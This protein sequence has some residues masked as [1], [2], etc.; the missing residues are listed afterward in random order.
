MRKLNKPCRRA[1]GNRCVEAYHSEGGTHD[2]SH[3]IA[4]YGIAAVGGA[5]AALLPGGIATGVAGAIATAAVDI[6]GGDAAGHA[7]D[8]G[9]RYNGKA[10]ILGLQGNLAMG[11]ALSDAIGNAVNASPNRTSSTRPDPFGG[12]NFYGQCYEH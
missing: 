12:C 8:Q 2:L 4:D 9:I 5:G 3:S 11:R 1:Y 10:T 7:L 6:H